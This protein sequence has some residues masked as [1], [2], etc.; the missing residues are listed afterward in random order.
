MTTHELQQKDNEAFFAH[1]AE[2][3]YQLHG[4]DKS[5]EWMQKT[6]QNDVFSFDGA[7]KQR[8]A[9]KLIIKQA[10]RKRINAWLKKQVCVKMLTL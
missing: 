3:Y 2:G 6:L 8:Y 1:I 5:I 10:A 9:H 4:M 7:Y